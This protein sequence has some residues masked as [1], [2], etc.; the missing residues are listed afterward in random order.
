MKRITLGKALDAWIEEEGARAPDRH[1]EKTDE[2][3]SYGELEGYVLGTLQ[4][5]SRRQAHVRQCRYCQRG[6]E[7]YRQHAPIDVRP[8]ARPIEWVCR[9]WASTSD[10]SRPSSAEAPAVVLDQIARDVYEVTITLYQRPLLRADGVLFLSIHLSAGNVP[11]GKRTALEVVDAFT[12][13]AVGECECVIGTDTALEIALP[14][15]SALADRATRLDSED[16]PLPLPYGSVWFRL[17]V[18]AELAAESD[19]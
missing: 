18:V 15:S 9:K 5:P 17:H 16:G 6:L 8:I 2:C 3:L 10:R 12:S 4:L 1:P 7:T 14:A 19:E 11:A 13:E